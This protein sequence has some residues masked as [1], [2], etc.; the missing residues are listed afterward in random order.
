[1]GPLT[2]PL[3]CAL[4]LPG[5]LGSHPESARG[6]FG[7][8]SSPFPPLRLMQGRGGEGRWPAGVR[9]PRPRSG[10]PPHT[11]LPGAVSGLQVTTFER[12][13]FNFSSVTA[14]RSCHCKK[15]DIFVITM[16]RLAKFQRILRNVIRIFIMH[17][18]MSRVLWHWGFSAE[19][20]IWPVSLTFP[21]R[22]G[23]SQNLSSLHFILQTSVHLTTCVLARRCPSLC[24]SFRGPFRQNLLA[25]PTGK[26]TVVCFQP[27]SCQETTVSANRDVRK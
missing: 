11:K 7:C 14:L 13:Q 24:A 23:S 19:G 27:H 16:I 5:V 1:M 9:S 26:A 21:D 20:T 22:H 3:W 10:R 15:H 18:L 2:S 6:P 4:Q 12:A 8:P 25:V 17:Y